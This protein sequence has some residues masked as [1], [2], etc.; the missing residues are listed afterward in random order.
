MPLGG[1]DKGE[2]P[3]VAALRELEEETGYRPAHVHLMGEYYSS[4]GMVS[5]SFFLVRATGLERV[6]AGG[7]VGDE[8]ISVHRVPINGLAAFIADKRAQGCAMDVKLLMLL[9]PALWTDDPAG[10]PDARF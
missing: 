6:G 1:I 5:E 2:E 3:A 9:G 10:G 7:G 8:N 4:P